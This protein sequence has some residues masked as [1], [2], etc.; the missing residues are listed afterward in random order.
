MQRDAKELWILGLAFKSRCGP[1]G[2]VTGKVRYPRYDGVAVCTDSENLIDI[3]LGSCGPD[4]AIGCLS[5]RFTNNNSRLE[6]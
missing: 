3:G 4:I 2:T 1:P 6:G 5:S